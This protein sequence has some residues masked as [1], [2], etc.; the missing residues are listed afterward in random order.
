MIITIFKNTL[1]FDRSITKSDNP[2]KCFS[3]M[4]KHQ[5]THGDRKLLDI[6]TI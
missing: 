5:G 4:I 2:N 3:V 1:D 6:L